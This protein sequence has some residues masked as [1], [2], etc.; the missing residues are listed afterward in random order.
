[1][2]KLTD[3]ESVFRISEYRSLHQK[4]HF[5]FICTQLSDMSED[6]KVVSKN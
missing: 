1:M 2:H 5:A 3:V 6:I 4:A